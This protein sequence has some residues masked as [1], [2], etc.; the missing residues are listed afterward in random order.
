[1]NLRR[2]LRNIW[3]KVVTGLLRS[4]GLLAEACIAW[5]LSGHS[6]SVSCI[7]SEAMDGAMKLARQVRDLVYFF[8]EF[9]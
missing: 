2:P 5:R 1:M 8:S 6:L 3:W 4:S 7:G 9:C